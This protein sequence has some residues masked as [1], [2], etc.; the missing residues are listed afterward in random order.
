LFHVTM[1]GN[2]LQRLG[3]TFNTSQDLEGAELYAV[4]PIA[5]AGGS[6][7]QLRSISFLNE[8]IGL[9]ATEGDSQ[10][11]I[12]AN[13]PSAL[14]LANVTPGAGTSSSGRV[15]R[16]AEIGA[17]GAKLAIGAIAGRPLAA[18]SCLEGRSVYIVDLTSMETRAVVPNLSGPF[19]VAFDEARKRLYVTDFRSSVIR[20]VDLSQLASEQ[21]ALESVRVVATR[22][23]PRVVQELKLAL[24]FFARARSG[25]RSP[26]LCARAAR[27]ASRRKRRASIARPTSTSCA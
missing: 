18:V 13:V 24:D 12:I 1:L 9:G 20:V 2:A 14:V 17:G 25:S 3:V 4:T 5:I 10:A 19:G 23:R 8:P 26:S 21:A 6:L 11:L 7:N 16:L 15:Q 27:R 22:G